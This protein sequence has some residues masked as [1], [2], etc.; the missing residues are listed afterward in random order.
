MTGILPTFASNMQTKVVLRVKIS[1]IPLTSGIES[2]MYRWMAD[3]CR[4][5]LKIIAFFVIKSQS[6]SSNY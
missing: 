3:M 2:K 6:G 4:L 5:L 1:L